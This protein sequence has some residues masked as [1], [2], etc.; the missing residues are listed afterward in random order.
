MSSRKRVMINEMLGKQIN[1]A[2]IEAKKNKADVVMPE[3]I[4]IKLLENDQTTRKL[5]EAAGLEV[6]EANRELK[7]YLEKYCYDTNSNLEVD[8]SDTAEEVI[9]NAVYATASTGKDEVSCERFVYEA[10]QAVENIK[11][12]FDDNGFDLTEFRVKAT[13]MLDNDFDEDE[14]E[15]EDS[16]KPASLLEEFTTNVTQKARDGEIDPIIGRNKELQRT[17]QI[18]SRKSKNN[19]LHVG[20]PGVGKTA[21]TNGLALKIINDDVPECLKGTEIYSIEMGSMLAGTKYRG[22]FEERLKK[23]LKEIQSLDNAIL[24]IDEIHTIVGAGA[25]QG[26]S[27]DAA[28][29]LKPLLTEGKLKV[30]GAT[31]DEEYRKYFEKDAALS[32]RFQKVAVNEPSQEDTLKI[33]K[34]LKESYENFHNVAYTDSVLKYAI[35]MSVKFINNRYLP[36]KAIDLIDEA[37]ARTKL[38]NKKKVTTQDIDAVISLV[39]NIPDKNMKKNDLDILMN[40]EDNIKTK[41]FGQD[42]AIKAV[43]KQ[44]K[45][46]KSGL[47][48]RD[49]PIASCLFVGPTGTGKTELCKQLSEEF[50]I[51][52]VRFDMS[53]YS[54][55]GSVAK[56][57][58]TAPGYVGY[59]NGGVLVKKLK[60]TPSCILLLD[61]IEKAHDDIYNILLQVMD[62]G[63]LSDN[64]GNKI[65]CKNVI[66]I[67]TSNCGAAEVGR[68][69]IGLTNKT[70][71]SS[72]ILETVKKKFKPEFRNRL[73]SIVVFN[74]LSK[75]MLKKVAVREISSLTSKLNSKGIEVTVNDDVY[76]KIVTEAEKTFGAREVVRL[77]DSEIK[78]YFVDLLFSDFDKKPVVVEVEDD[79]FKFEIKK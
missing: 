34:G 21:I 62:Y 2:V 27:M 35:E 77:V 17:I 29:M 18:L 72:N 71:D 57:I 49:K 26:G 59:E 23:L 12:I 24:F 40:L 20:L 15:D 61:E 75:D 16:A 48:D 19:P 56:L 38:N 69:K 67:M 53:E 4:V 13:N 14:D 50:D 79:K 1:L 76:D 5:F 7:A 65:D 68:T 6:T 64:E 78:D 74:K 3:E 46:S 33:L 41:I 36:D 25:S 66:L 28:N 22:D 54:E 10:Y 39:A 55:K 63:T 9:N 70:V 58:G 44:I 11:D 45:R 51:P 8:M 30:I 31:T 73:D 52:L 43:V 47:D 37:G 60:N 32:R 42:E